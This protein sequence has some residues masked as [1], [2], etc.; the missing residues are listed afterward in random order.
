MD[1]PTYETVVVPT[2]GSE[3]AQRGIDH[4][5]EIAADNDATVHFVHVMDESYT[6]RPGIKEYEVSIEEMRNEALGELERLKRAAE[7]HGLDAVVYC[8]TGTP[9]EEITAYADRVGADLIVMGK[10]GK[11]S[12][13]TPHVGRIADRVLRT[14]DIPV[15]T[16]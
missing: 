10:R 4:G 5:L 7:D 14:A 9:H 11:G 8:T 12:A 2:D 15:F 3:P 1:T 13:D 6:E 16:V